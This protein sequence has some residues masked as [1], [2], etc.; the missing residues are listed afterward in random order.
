MSLVRPGDTG[1]CI[2]NFWKI[3][4]AILIF[5]FPAAPAIEITESPDHLE[6]GDAVTLD[7][8][9]LTDNTTFGIQILG[10]FTV[11][12][13]SAFTFETRN[14]VMPITLK[15]GEISASVDNAKTAFFAVQKGEVHASVGK[16]SIPDGHFVYSDSQT[17]PV[18]TYDSLALTGT[19]VDNTH[20]VNT[21]FFLQ[22]KKSGPDNSRISFIL[23]GIDAGSVRITAYENSEEVFSKDIVIGT[24]DPEKNF[25]YAGNM[26][27]RAEDT[28]KTAAAQII[29]GAAFIVTLFLYKRYP[30]S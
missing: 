25:G 18:G 19:V 1:Y 21:R 22:G 14:F 24:L 11:Q 17:I 3:L 15:N 5:A 29:P 28:P 9:G 2:R 16:D 13:G 23:S 8:A 20:P 4:V 26:T 7:I 30:L 6:N 12:P 27:A 10:S